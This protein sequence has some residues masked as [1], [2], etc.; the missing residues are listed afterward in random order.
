MFRRKDLPNYREVADYNRIKFYYVFK[1]NKLHMQ[2]R[3]PAYKFQ[4]NASRMTLTSFLSNKEPVLHTWVEQPNFTLPDLL[5]YQY[6]KYLFALVLFFFGTRCINS[7]TVYVLRYEVY[8]DCFIVTLIT[9]KN[10]ASWLLFQ[11]LSYAATNSLRCSNVAK[12][13]WKNY[14]YF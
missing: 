11:D 1:Y 8:P 2:S 10:N 6:Y 4:I 3:K 9:L 13:S 5:C 12:L 14:I 7:I